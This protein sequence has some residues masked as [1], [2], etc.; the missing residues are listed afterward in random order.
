MIEVVDTRRYVPEEDFDR[1]RIPAVI[2]IAC[3]N[4]DHE[5]SAICGVE[6][7]CECPCRGGSG[8]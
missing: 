8:L 2:C 7:K 6:Q 1:S 4:G 3:E 5:N